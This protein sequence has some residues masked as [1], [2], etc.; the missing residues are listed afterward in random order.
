M[1]WNALENRLSQT[2]VKEF[3][4]ALVK[5]WNNKDRMTVEDLMS[6]DLEL[7]EPAH[8]YEHLASIES[9]IF[10]KRLTWN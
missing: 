5:K 6:L 2:S 7:D 9:E 3:E 4:N 8:S 10:K 1:S